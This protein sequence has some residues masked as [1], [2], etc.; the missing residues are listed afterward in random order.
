MATSKRQDKVKQIAAELRKLCERFGVEILYAFGSR[1]GEVRAAVDAGCDIAES[2]TS[3]VDIG[4]KLSPGRKASIREKVELAMRL[5]DLFGIGKVDL[6]SLSDADPF[7]AV[8]IIRGERLFSVDER[9]ADE[10]DLY[11]LRRAG[12]LAYFERRRIES[13]LNR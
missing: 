9:L 3:D 13:V 7:L 12:D 11:V 2:A 6:V 5:E 10:Y 4:A 1:A 8:N